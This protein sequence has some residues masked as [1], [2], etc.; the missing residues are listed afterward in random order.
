MERVNIGQA[1]DHL[2]DVVNKVVDDG[3]RVVI[4]RRGRAVAVI[5]P[6]D[7]LNLL[8]EVEVRLIAEDARLAMNVFDDGGGSEVPWEVIQDTLLKGR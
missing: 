8:E 3:E 7:D 6:V 4:N 5:V 2:A 1:R